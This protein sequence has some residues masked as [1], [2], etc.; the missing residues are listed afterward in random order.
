MCLQIPDLGRVWSF[1]GNEEGH[2]S[3]VKLGHLSSS[4]G[5]QDPWSELEYLTPTQAPEVLTFC[6]P[7][8]PAFF[9]CVLSVTA[10]VSSLRSWEHA[11]A[12]R[13]STQLLSTRMRFLLFPL[14]LTLCE[15]MDCSPP[16]SSVHGILQARLLEWVA[17]L[18]QGIFPTQGSNHV[19]YVSCIDRCVL[20]H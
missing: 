5:D 20:C 12:G 14:C 17:T 2:G 18:L 4:P 16:G 1:G 15:S 8:A 10:R 6:L 9:V 7:G 19:F 3:W 13:V 11:P